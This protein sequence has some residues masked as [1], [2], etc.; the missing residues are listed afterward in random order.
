MMESLVD[1]IQRLSAQLS[2]FKQLYFIQRREREM[3]GEKYIALQDDFDR[4]KQVLHT[5]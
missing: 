1:E 4:N 2:N 3:A 5:A